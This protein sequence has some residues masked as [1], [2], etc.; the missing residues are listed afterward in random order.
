MG[1]VDVWEK[2]GVV[3]EVSP[4]PGK[5]WKGSGLSNRK[6]VFSNFYVQMSHLGDHVKNVDFLSVGLGWG[7]SVCISN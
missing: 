2:Y 7:L 5:I 1:C 6:E 4:K 3:L